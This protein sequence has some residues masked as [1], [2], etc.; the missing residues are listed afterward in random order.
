MCK[1]LFIQ[2]YLVIYLPQRIPSLEK[3]ELLFNSLS[4]SPTDGIGNL[5]FTITSL[6]KRMSTP[7]PILPEA[8]GATTTGFA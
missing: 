2:L 5:S 1:L 3:I 6:A 7:R 8:L 4:T